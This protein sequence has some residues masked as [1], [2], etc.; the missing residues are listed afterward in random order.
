MG[1]IVNGANGGFSGKAGSVVGASW[2]GLNYIRGIARRS[3]KPA[4]TA[5][6]LHRQKFL[7]IKDLVAPIK[8]ILDLS[9]QNEGA[10]FEQGMNKGFRR[11]MTGDAGIKLV[12]DVPKLKGEG[13]TLSAGT[14][15]IMKGST[16]SS[17]DGKFTVAWEAYDDGAGDVPTRV[18]RSSIMDDK[19]YVVLYCE[20]QRAHLCSFA[21]AKRSEE[22]VEIVVPAGLGGELFHGFLFFSDPGYKVFSASEYLGEFTAL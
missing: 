11:N 13:I 2:R 20:K 18:K 12:N 4:S 16:L 19:V 9:L 5:Q 6:Q 8:D 7:V 14:C 3:N 15:P 1:I 10:F 17:A 22:K 21:K